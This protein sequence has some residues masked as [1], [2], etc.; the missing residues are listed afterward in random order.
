MIGFKTKKEF[1]IFMD[2]EVKRV[3]KT[4]F[5]KPKEADPTKPIYLYHGTS[6][7]NF[8]KIIKQGIKPR[9][10]KAS[11]WKGIGISRPDLVY[12]TNCYASYYAIC[13]MGEK[14]KAVVIRVKID[15]KKIKLY[16]DEEFLYH[17][18]RFHQSDNLQMSKD[19]Y[20]TINPKNL[21]P[22]IKSQLKREVTWVDSLNYLGTV[23]CD[24]VPVENIVSY[25]ILDKKDYLF[26]DPSINP[27][28]YKICSGEYIYHLERLNYKPFKTK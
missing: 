20:S 2:N 24:Y 5:N 13:A 28:N 23:S 11:N 3:S 4:M 15:P 18:L 9:G 7:S 10:R 8:K 6:L 26:C 21:N 14:D 25:A 12:L 27:L 1:D 17:A 22:L 19:L 16:L